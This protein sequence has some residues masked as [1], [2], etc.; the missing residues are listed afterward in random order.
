MKNFAFN[1]PA[2]T[3]GCNRVFCFLDADANA[4]CRIVIDLF[5]EK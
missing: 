4:Y 1:G 3:E 5:L 2:F